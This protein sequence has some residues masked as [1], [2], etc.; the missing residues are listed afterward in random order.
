MEDDS[1][2]V[3]GSGG[4][5]KVNRPWS[6]VFKVSET[7]SNFF[8][9]G[10]RAQVDR[11]ESLNIWE[12]LSVRVLGEVWAESRDTPSFIRFTLKVLIVSPQ[13]TKTLLI[14]RSHRPFGGDT[15]IERNRSG[16]LESDESTPSTPW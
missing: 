14:S 5:E 7:N 3:R 13:V 15:V 16:S 6:G 9:L 10:A 2:E 8:Q 11:T 4:V 1:G 12:I